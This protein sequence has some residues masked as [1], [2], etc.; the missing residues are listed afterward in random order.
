MK[1]ALLRRWGLCIF[2]TAC[3]FLWRPVV[4]FLV[5]GVFLVYVNDKNRTLGLVHY[6]TYC[7]GISMCFWIVLFWYLRYVP[8]PLSQLVGLVFPVSVVLLGLLALRYRSVPVSCGRSD[9]LILAVMVLLLVLRLKAMA[10]VI[11]PAGADMSMHTYIA[12]LISMAN[13]IPGSYEPL[14]PIETFSTFPVGFH[15]LTAIISL[16][17]NM[18][19]YR[20]GLLMTCMTYFF[21]T[22]FSYA[23]LRNWIGRANALV[24]SVVVSYF[25]Y[26]PGGFI[27]W[28]G[29]PTV[30]AIA[31]VLL[32]LTFK[33]S[34]DLSPS[35]SILGSSLTLAGILLIHIIIFIQA[36]YLLLF[37]LPV[38][39]WQRGRLRRGE[40][41]AF[42]AIA[43][44]FIFLTLPYILNIDFGVVTP[45]TLDLMKNWVRN[46][47]HAWQGDYKNAFWSV[48]VYI[49]RRLGYHYIFALCVI[50]GSAWIK[51][52]FWKKNK[53]I[54]VACTVYVLSAIVLIVNTRYWLLPF[55]FAIYPERVVAMLIIPFAIV[56]GLA[57][58]HLLLNDIRFRLQR[59]LP[60]SL[61]VIFVFM[62]VARYNFTHFEAHLIRSSSVTRDDLRGLFWLREN[63]KTADVVKNNYGD[64]GAWIPA[65]AMRPATAAHVNFAYL[66]KMQPLPDPKYVFVGSKCVYQPCSITAVTMAADP[67]FREVFHSGETFVYK[68]RER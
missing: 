40:I 63:T 52:G 2:F 26:D 3:C 4:V 41:T 5:P 65:I 57:L 45:K 30:L 42:A 13:G 64:A 37:T 54:I 9:L 11:V 47:E 7:L 39:Y 46:T 24:A 59:F 66:D 33:E 48:P 55:S 58:D 21:L 16:T 49:A 27:I 35:V 67:A 32:F 51:K 50:A 36:F 68:R 15:V 18:E 29:N 12:A 6:I 62:V 22:L 31:M 56:C 28:G 25:F 38:Y 19:V 1:M 14:V 44:L 43:V 8:V 17:G 53:E 60:V 23:L 20:A 61:A 34:R 10:S